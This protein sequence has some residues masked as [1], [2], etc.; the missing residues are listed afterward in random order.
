VLELKIKIEVFLIQM[1]HASR[2]E[3]H[4]ERVAAI[5]SSLDPNTKSMHLEVAELNLYSYK[6]GEDGHKRS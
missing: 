2:S 4:L 1:E 5:A 3:G 6:V